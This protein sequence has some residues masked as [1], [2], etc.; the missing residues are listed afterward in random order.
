MADVKNSVISAG[1]DPIDLVNRNE[2]RLHSAAHKKA[3]LFPANNFPW[4]RDLRFGLG[5]TS[6]GTSERFGQARGRDRFE[7][8]IDRAGFE[9]VHGVLIKRCH[10]NNRWSR[11]CAE[12]FRH[13]KSAHARHLNVEQEQVG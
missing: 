6:A 13:V 9:S 7:Q 3:T 8:I 5:Q 2:S 4:R 10:E 12:C 11:L 1:L